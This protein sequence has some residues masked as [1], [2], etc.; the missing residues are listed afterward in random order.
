M[1][2]TNLYN[3]VSE[4]L[5]KK[6]ML[7]PGEQVVYRLYNMQKNPMNPEKIAIPSAKNVP[8]VDTIWDEEKSE[9][10]DIACIKS[11]DAQGNH[12]FQEIFFYG[13]M[14]GHLILQ[15]GRAFDQEIHTYLTLCDYNASKPNRD[16]T[17]EI[18]FERV[19][20]EVKAE[21]ESRTRNIRREALNAAADLTPEEVKDYAAA[22]GKDDSKPVKVLRNE[23]EEMA[24]SQP[25]DFMSLINNKQAVMKATINRAL[26]KN[27]LVFNEEQSRFEW[28]NKEAILTVA[29]TTG[30]DAIEELISFCISSAKGEK[31]FQ[32]IQSKAKK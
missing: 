8:P 11:V 23:L 6:T 10:V 5:V 26:K 31:V 32:T 2:K 15:G 20:E 30:S 24:D 16:T 14:A 1:R 12:N 29:R 9:Y 25:E 27:A 3:G 4:S 17:K 13:N 22:L 28:P 19:D 18:I 21:K 7:K